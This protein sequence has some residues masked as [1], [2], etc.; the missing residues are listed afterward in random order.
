MLLREI[1][2]VALATTV[3]LICLFGVLFFIASQCFTADAPQ[4]AALQP[5]AT[6]ASSQGGSNEGRQATATAQVPSTPTPRSTNTPQPAASPTV[7]SA[8]VVPATV[9]QPP[10][11]T[12]ATADFSGNWSVIDT[13]TAGTGAGQTF[14]FDV[15]LTQTGNSLSGGN[16]GIQISGAVSGSTATVTYAQP[17]LRLTG[18]FTWTMSN[19]GASGTFT[20]SVPNSGSSQ[21]IRR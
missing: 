21:L 6:T 4:Y 5:T 17:A 16:S 12:G 14:S 10:A 11:A 15:T 18:T 7:A 1:T 19:G 3:L 8:P 9:Q 20:S 2:S 13:V